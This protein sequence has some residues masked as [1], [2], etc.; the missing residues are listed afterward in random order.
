MARA[1]T[2]QELIHDA[3]KNFDALLTLIEDMKGRELEVPF[4][5]SDDPGK[6]EAHWRR[7]RNLR[8]VLI[9][10]HEWHQLLLHWVSSNMGGTPVPFLPP[11]YNWKTYGEMNVMLWEKHQGTSLPDAM[12]MVQASH[13]AV[14]ALAESL[15]EEQ[16][17]SKGGVPWSGGSTLGSYF[18][19]TTASHYVWAMKK[20]K[21]HR[22]R[23]A[24][25]K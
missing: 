25:L 11:P 17:F 8:D 20:L 2:K 1:A 12:E 23:A 22:K 7:D 9:H 6:K 15:T 3:R 5:F 16:L 21:A 4:D 19:S 10:L 13:N 24:V 14:V 18:V